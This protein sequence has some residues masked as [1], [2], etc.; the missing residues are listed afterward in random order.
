VRLSPMSLIG[1]M[2]MVDQDDIPETRQ[3]AIRRLIALLCGAG[4]RK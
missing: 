1:L 4:K 3:A 2:R